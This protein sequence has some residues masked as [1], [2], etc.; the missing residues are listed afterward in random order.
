[1]TSY[2]IFHSADFGG[3]PDDPDEI[4]YA[5]L[6]TFLHG[7][8]RAVLDTAEMLGDESA[9][10]CA[11]QYHSP[12]SGWEIRAI[13]ADDRE[14]FE[15]RLTAFFNLH[16]EDLINFAAELLT[17]NDRPCY[18]RSWPDGAWYRAGYL[19][20]FNARGEGIGFAGYGPAGDRLADGVRNERA[21]VSAIAYPED[22]A[23]CAV[24]TFDEI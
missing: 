1:M 9:E 14:R 22:H 3:D 4:H 21:A 12:R 2:S 5:Q 20:V 17:S 8:A 23:L 10:V 6:Q 24:V 11:E 7:A 18:V 16:R 15:G 19:Y 13:H